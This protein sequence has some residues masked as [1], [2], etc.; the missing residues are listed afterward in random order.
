MRNILQFSFIIFLFCGCQKDRTVKIS[1][2]MQQVYAANAKKV[3]VKS[4]VWGT[5]SFMEGNCMPTV[6]SANGSCKNCPVERTLKIYQ[7]TLSSNA[8]PSVNAVGFFD[9]FNT[10]LVAQ[11]RSDK[12]GFFQVNLPMG[13]YSIAVVENGKLYVNSYDA[14]GGLNPFMVAGGIEK[15]DISM[16][17]KAVF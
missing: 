10:Q 16:T 11:V 5:V 4:G 8:Q 7:Y 14:Q 9:D 15:V 1:C 6:E 3:S 17:Y 2:D 13:H 12:N